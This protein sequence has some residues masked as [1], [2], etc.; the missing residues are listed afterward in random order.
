MLLLN[1]L[2]NIPE[3]E[4][5]RMVTSYCFYNV[6]DKTNWH[7][8]T[9]QKGQPDEPNGSSMPNKNLAVNKPREK[10]LWQRNP[11]RG[12]ALFSAKLAEYEASV[13]LGGE[14]QLAGLM[15]SFVA[16]NEAW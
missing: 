3:F 13:V 15:L 12:A 2:K 7:H 1:L 4:P 10:P 5:L 9:E 11:K 14:S 8:A 6:F 16:A